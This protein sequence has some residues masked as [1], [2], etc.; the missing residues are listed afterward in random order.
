MLSK[1]DLESWLQRDLPRLDKLLLILTA[2]GK[3]CQIKEIKQCASEAGFRIPGRWNL[4]DVLGRSN[5]L[6]IR[7][8]IGW[9]ISEGGKLHLRGLGVTKISP[10]AVQVATD[11][12][13]ELQNIKNHDTRAFVEEAIRCYELE[14]HRSAIV[15]SWLAAVDVLH[16]YVHTSH[17]KA[18]NAEARRVDARWKPARSTDDLGK[19]PEVD[20]LER[21]NGLSIIGKNVK[22]ELKACLDRRNGC[23]HPNSLKIGANTVTHHIEILLLNVFKVFQ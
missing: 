21:L 13:Q 9:K 19:M 12:R 15:M 3:P 2:I 10:A 17:L 1:N 11:L 14:L 4:S 8:P 22:K 18:F 6:A 20:F 7:T 5:G 23:G 16:R